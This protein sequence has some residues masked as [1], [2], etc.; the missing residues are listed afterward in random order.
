MGARMTAAECLSSLAMTGAAVLTIFDTLTGQHA[1]ALPGLLCVIVYVLAVWPNVRTNSRIM[2]LAALAAM[3]V[4][5]LLDG[6]IDKFALVASRSLYLPALL[7]AMTLLRVA[8]QHSP[9]VQS[10]AHFVVDQPPRRRFWLLTTGGQLFGVLLNV[11]G[12]Q[13][14]LR[15]ALSGANRDG[16]DPKVIDIRTKRISNAVM[17]GFVATVLWSPI[18]VAM[19]LIL[20][21]MPTIRWV[22]YLPYGLGMLTL[23]VLT[24]WLLDIWE[25]R[26][27]A[28]V[29]T[30]KREGKIQAVFILLGLL[31]AITGLS[32]LGE[33]VLGIPLR[34]AVLLVVP[35]FAALWVLITN[36][37]APVPS[38]ATLGRNGFQELPS[39]VSEI[40]IM[41]S[42]SFLG[43]VIADLVPIQFVQDLVGALN[44][45]PGVIACLIVA[46]IALLSLVGINPLI[47][48]TAIVGALV[49][50]RIEMPE[51][52]LMAS[53]LSGWC[54]AMTVSP[55]TA[56]VAIAAEASG[57][58][59]G[60]VGLRWNGP[61]AFLYVLILIP[62]F[63]IWEKW[64]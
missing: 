50:A 9:Q 10:A 16:D 7:A 17:R 63:L 62:I 46:A 41:A 30:R 57:R 33:W 23:F 13:F 19:N 56:T 24:G 26:S 40:C 18:G 27:K 49:A 61:F 47:T 6:D 45:S 64:I 31:L 38:L 3:V 14:L 11:G 5:M 2:L 28:P 21:I 39:S 35:L 12:L 8:T 4:F 53:A 51:P 59:A 29:I 58:G 42:T 37:S 60:S 32:A 25:P 48:G 34:A 22:D 54:A 43:L 52:M 55:V 20:P 36:G 1:A 44:A 15:I